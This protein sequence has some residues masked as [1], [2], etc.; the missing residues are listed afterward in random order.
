MDSCTCRTAT[1]SPAEQELAFV[2]RDYITWGL[3]SWWMAKQGEPG[4][5]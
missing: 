2:V 5:A 3:V 1:V 4:V